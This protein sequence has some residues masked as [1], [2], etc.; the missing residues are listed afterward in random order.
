[1][2]GPGN[3]YIILV[4]PIVIV[5]T[6]AVIYLSYLLNCNYYYRSLPAVNIITVTVSLT[7]IIFAIVTLLA[8]IQL[9]CQLFY[10]L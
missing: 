1:M 8:I 2:H 4:L 3:T 9:L 6:L 10:L 7:V 5:V